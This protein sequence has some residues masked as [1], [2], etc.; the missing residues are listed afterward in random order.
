MFAARTRPLLT[1][2]VSGGRFRSPVALAVRTP[3]VSTVAWSRCVT[4]VYWGCWLPGTPLI[5][6][7]GMLVQVTE[8]FQPAFFSQAVRFFLCR[9]DGFTRRAIQR[10]PSGQI[11]G[12]QAG[13][14]VN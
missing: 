11:P 7:C 8:Y 4:P 10:S 1:R 2:Q 12:L 5:P 3:S 6:V 9:R 14:R 13:E